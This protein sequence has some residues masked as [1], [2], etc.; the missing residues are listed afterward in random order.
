MAYCN[1]DEKIEL[2]KK[3]ITDLKDK[4]KDIFLTSHYPVPK[5]LIIII[6]IAIMIY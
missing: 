2:L 6:M 3:C 1:T 4:N 5:W